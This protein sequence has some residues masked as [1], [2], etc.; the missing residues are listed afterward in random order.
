MAS[1]SAQRGKARAT[2]PQQPP[3][4]PPPPPPLPAQVHGRDSSAERVPPPPP[5]PPPQLP[6]GGAS[7]ERP[8]LD[9]VASFY[10]LIE[11]HVTASVLGRHARSAELCGRAAIQAEAFFGGDS[12]IWTDLRFREATAFTNQSVA[13]ADADGHALASQAWKLLL[14]LHAILLRRHAANTLLAV[15]REEADYDAHAQAFAHKSR[16]KLV[17]S[18]VGVQLGQAVFGF[19]ILL[20]VTAVTL[21]LL[22]CQ[23]WPRDEVT[24][25]QSFVLDALNVIPLTAGSRVIVEYEPILVAFVEDMSKHAYDPAFRDAVLRKW[26]SP[27]VSNVLRSHGTLQTGVASI[28]REAAEYDARRRADIEKIGLRECAWPSCDKVERTVREFKQ[29]SGCRSVW[30]CSPEHQMLDWGV[31]RTACGELDVARKKAM[32][33][34]AVKGGA[35]GAFAAA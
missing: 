34:E 22:R 28:E 18:R 35:G 27:A 8:R 2:P 9:Q 16:D 15:R 20:G 1:S 23:G 11:R 6:G 19:A 31:H 17:V 13:T 4:P 33:S 3:P 21:N 10:E 14:P 7:A 24:R 26:R 29:C 5:P 25:A 30:Y 12:L 32:K